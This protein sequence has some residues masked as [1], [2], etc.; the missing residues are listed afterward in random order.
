[1]IDTFAFGGVYRMLAFIERARVQKS[2]GI[3]HGI[4][5]SDTYFGK[6]HLLGLFIALDLFLFAG[7][8][9]EAPT[10]HQ[11]MVHKMGH[12]VM[13]FELSKTMHIFEMTDSGGIQQVI[14][15]DPNDS[16]QILV[17]Q[18]HLQH[19][20][21]L[22]KNGDISDPA[23]LHGPSMPGLKDLAAGA[24]SI[25]IEYSSIP[26]GGQI[27]FKTQDVHLITAIHRWFGAQLSEHGYDAIS[28]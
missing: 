13:P 17:I 2:Q 3:S 21:M 26:N 6:I 24:P 19:E 14:A 8:A 28:R 18:N 11:A 7:C 23:L 15:K 5:Q 22:F 16:E 10:S 1:M 9:H 25:E 27:T 20:A 4:Y 12:E